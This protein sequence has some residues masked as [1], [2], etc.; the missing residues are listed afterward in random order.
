V[1]PKPDTQTLTRLLT[2]V[3][4]FLCV[5]AFVGPVLVL[6]DNSVLT[7]S[8]KQIQGFTPVAQ[9]EIARRQ[10]WSVW[11][12][13]AAP[14]VGLGIFG[15]GLVLLGFA[16]PRLRNQESASDKRAALEAAQLEQQ[17]E[18]QT[19]EERADEA[20][21]NVFVSAARR[22]QTMSGDDVV[23]DDISETVERA[24]EPIPEPMPEPVPAEQLHI[25]VPDSTF[26]QM[27]SPPETTQTNVLDRIE[28]LVP[29]EFDFRRTVKLIGEGITTD[30]LFSGLL[31]ARGAM[32]ADVIVD[33]RLLTGLLTAR[34]AGQMAVD[35]GA[36]RLA[37]GNRTGRRSGGWIVLVW[38]R[39]AEATEEER[40]L[41]R[42]VH[43][44]NSRVRISAVTEAQIPELLPPAGIFR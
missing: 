16:Y 25:E 11:E 28:K 26:E 40:D 21:G 17:L 27:W 1:I 23:V 20:I 7:L 8:A 14:W 9:R 43:R 35:M 29:E 12:A 19:P 2:S 38:D 39:A 32:Y 44:L 37:Y 33:V 13:G 42:E 30:I 3:G 31:I 24:P 41:I 15:A 4:L 22:W 18:P 5:V 34:H 6:R 10:R 36:K